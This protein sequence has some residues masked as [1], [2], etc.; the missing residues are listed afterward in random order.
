MST[1]I[2]SIKQFFCEKKVKSIV[3][4]L[5]VVCSIY[6]FMFIIHKRPIENGDFSE[7]LEEL[8]L[9][10]KKLEQLQKQYDTLIS[11]QNV[12]LQGLD[13]KIVN[14][15][16]KTTIVRE[17]YHEVIKNV[18]NYNSNQVD[19]FFKNRYNY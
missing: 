13:D 7:R 14:I 2:S 15:K 5:L 19:S 17:Y 16:E 3:Y 9:K 1:V 10:T 6:C 18:D 11:A 8:D 12:K 4:F